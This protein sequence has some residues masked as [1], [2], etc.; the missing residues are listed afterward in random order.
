MLF[1]IAKATS[2]K[3]TTLPEK[4]LPVAAVN[5]AIFN[6]KNEVLLT[7]RS[8][9]VRE[10]GKW[11]LPGGHFEGGE[12]WVEAMRRETFEEVGIEVLEERLIGIYSDPQLTVTSQAAKDG[13]HRQFLAILF[14]VTRFKGEVKPN[15]E[16]D[17][18][19]WYHLN[20]LPEPMLR[21]HPIRVQDAIARS[22][23]VFVR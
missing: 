11:C 15:E 19:G 20:N 3:M 16:V 2:K 10:P 22:P 23:F 8:A 21:S 6:S 4:I 18:W 13:F 5:A 14:E 1:F 17:Q 9:M 12:T 7:R